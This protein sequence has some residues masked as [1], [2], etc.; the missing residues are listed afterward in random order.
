[1]LDPYVLLTFKGTS[2]K[3]PGQP[4]TRAPRS[5]WGCWILTSSLLLKELSREVTGQPRREAPRS[6]WGC[7]ILTSSLLLKEL[8]REEP[9]QARGE[10]LEGGGDARS[11]RGALP[12]QERSSQKLLGV[13]DP[14]VLLIFKGVPQRETLPAQ[15]RGS[16]KLP[17][18]LDPYVLLTF[19]G[20]QQRGAPR[21]CQPRRE[22][23][24]SCWG[25]WILTS[26]LLLKELV[27]RS[28]ASPGQGL[29][30]VAGGAGSLRPPYF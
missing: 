27:E 22:A 23:P 11:Q 12:A 17:G 7:W 20:T 4:K 28:P 14:Y 19:K 13:L 1:M 21:P 18:V 25:C 5:C 29:T 3:E 9:C 16:E 26:S 15:G 2:R 8:N 24:R 30:E 6:S 10:A